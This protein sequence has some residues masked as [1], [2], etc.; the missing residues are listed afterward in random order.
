LQDGHGVVLRKNLVLV[1]VGVVLER[2]NHGLRRL[3][4]AVHGVAH[5]RIAVLH[6]DEH[7][8]LTRGLRVGQG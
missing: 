1:G 6:D 5:G 2:R 8:L 7:L 4:K 3:R